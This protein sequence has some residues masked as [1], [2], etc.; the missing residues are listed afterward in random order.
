MGWRDYL[1]DDERAELADLEA[2]IAALEDQLAP[3]K[4]RL[5]KIRDNASRRAT[6]HEG[7]KRGEP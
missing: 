7:P 1:T 3:L 5:K 2:R 6:H 4:A